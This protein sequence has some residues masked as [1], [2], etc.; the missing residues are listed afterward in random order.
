NKFGQIIFEDIL[1]FEK[2]KDTVPS[3]KNALLIA[4]RHLKKAEQ[5]APEEVLCDFKDVY[6]KMNNVKPSPIFK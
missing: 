2:I 3:P 5:I 6:V 4:E 1:I